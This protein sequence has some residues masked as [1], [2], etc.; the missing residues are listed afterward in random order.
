MKSR[1]GFFLLATVW[2]L[3]GLDAMTQNQSR[4]AAPDA[5]V[6]IPGA[7]TWGMNTP[8]AKLVLR[9]KSRAEVQGT[10]VITY[11]LWTTG[12]P[13]DL[14]YTMWIWDVGTDPR[15]AANVLLND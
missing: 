7:K 11:E 6:V 3:T 15:S 2:V 13:K 1:T 10:L 12:L 9:E 5:S 14:D 8:G 4:N